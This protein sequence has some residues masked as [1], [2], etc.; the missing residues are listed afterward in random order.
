[1]SRSDAEIASMRRFEALP[2]RAGLLDSGK[3]V[4]GENHP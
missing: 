3:V 2:D 1:M 4:R